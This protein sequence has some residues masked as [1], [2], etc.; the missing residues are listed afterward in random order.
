MGLFWRSA[1]SV[2]HFTRQQRQGAKPIYQ[3]RRSNTCPHPESDKP[4]D[5]VEIESALLLPVFL[6]Q[7]RVNVDIQAQPR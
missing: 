7:Q 5:L 2:H 6:K 4:I 3:T 1:W